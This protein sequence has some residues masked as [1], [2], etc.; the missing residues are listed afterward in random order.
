MFS[1]KELFCWST[2]VLVIIAG[3]SWLLLSA[4][5]RHIKEREA[6]Q[7]EAIERCRGVEIVQKTQDGPF[8]HLVNAHG[9]GSVSLNRNEILR[10][11]RKASLSFVYLKGLRG[12]M[13]PSHTVCNSPET[14]F[15]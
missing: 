7:M 9:G 8:V 10:V 11:E 1:W 13:G 15:Q 6:V 2:L 5:N 4:E 3:F 12:Y 14:F